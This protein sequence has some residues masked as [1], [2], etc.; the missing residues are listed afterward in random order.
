MFRIKPTQEP[1]SVVRA[2]NYIFKL[3]GRRFYSRNE[4]IQR[5]KRKGFNDQVC[6]QVME[7]VTEYGYIDDTELAKRELEQC[8]QRKK[9]GPNRIKLRLQKRGIAPEIICEIM[10]SLNTDA[11]YRL[12]FELARSKL[13]DMSDPNPYKRQ[14][15]LSS[16]LFRRGFEP[17]CIKQC[18]R[19]LIDV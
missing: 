18:L 5:L 16:F 7:L 9:L 2:K 4:L 11:V 3:L 10:D 8:L 6:R 19:E 14:A 17:D 15:R 13:A 12:C 1:D